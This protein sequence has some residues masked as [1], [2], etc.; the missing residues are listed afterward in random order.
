MMMVG[1]G[2]LGAAMWWMAEGDEPGVAFG[3]LGFASVVATVVT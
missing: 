1:S 2:L 3:C